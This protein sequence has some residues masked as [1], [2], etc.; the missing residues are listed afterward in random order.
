M[1][2]DEAQQLLAACAAYDNRQPSQIAK[3][4]WAAALKKIPLDD[5]CF[6]AVAR[7][8]AT[9]A[10]DGG[11]LWIQPA[12]VVTHRRA[13]RAERLENFVY[14]PPAGL[15]DPDFIKRLRGQQYA[16]GSGTAPAP[17]RAPALTGGPTKQVAEFL[18][19]VGR[20]IPAEDDETAAVRRPGPLGVECPKCSAP[21]GRP[22]RTPRGKERPTHPAR[23]GEATD[24]QAEQAEIEQRLAASAAVLRRLEAGEA[25]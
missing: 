12:D 11:R 8:Y 7:Y 21:I 10:K 2:P 13:V 15:D 20:D 1:T 23:S 5:D 6:E 19:S 16:V 4:A 3:R 18:A 9:P 14:E 17:S 24:P 25:L 22:C